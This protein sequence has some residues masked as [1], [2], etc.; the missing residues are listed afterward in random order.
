[1]NEANTSVAVAPGLFRQMSPPVLFG[2]RCERCGAH[3]FPS[4][5]H[6]RHPGCRGARVL[7][8]DLGRHGR[9]Y[10]YTIQHYRPPPPFSMEPWAPYAIG[11]VELPEGLRLL[12]MICGVPFAELEIGME[13]ELVSE[14]LHR[15]AEGR[16]VLTYK[17]TRLAS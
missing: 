2:S 8:V 6:C 16:E 17:F 1:M 10:S 3:Y 9:L 15:D 7:E 14:A 4:T 11:I 12:A 5:S 13:V